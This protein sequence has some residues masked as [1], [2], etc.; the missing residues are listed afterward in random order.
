[1]SLPPLGHRV[2][3][4]GGIPGVRPETRRDGG[5]G[6]LS[7]NSSLRRS[8]APRARVALRGP[9]L[10]MI[11]AGALMLQADVRAGAGQGRDTRPTRTIRVQG[12]KVSLE[13]MR[14]LEEKLAKDRPVG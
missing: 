7:K 12:L 13:E 1:M 14:R 4:A 6:M 11:L 2:P 8:G 3:V 10:S 9:T 5:Q